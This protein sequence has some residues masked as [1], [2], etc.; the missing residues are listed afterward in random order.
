MHEMTLAYIDTDLG[1]RLLEELK[2]DGWKIVAQY[3]PLA[4]DKGIDYDSYKLHRAGSELELEWDNWFEW[5]VSGSRQLIE[6][7]ARRFSLPI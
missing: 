1:N 7:L 4:F 6:E 5:K 2:G 3:S